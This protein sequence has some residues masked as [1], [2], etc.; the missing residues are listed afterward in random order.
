M[1]VLLLKK[2]MRVKNLALAG[3]ELPWSVCVLTA[4]PK[5]A[6]QVRRGVE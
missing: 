2:K 1:Y 4:R 3:F 5:W 6:E